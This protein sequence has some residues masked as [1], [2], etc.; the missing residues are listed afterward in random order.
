MADLALDFLR[1]QAL[2]NA[3]SC[4]TSKSYAI[5]LQQFF[6][7]VS[8]SRPSFKMG[9]NSINLEYLGDFTG[10]EQV[11]LTLWDEDLLLKWVFQAQ[12]SWASLSL[13][14]RNRKASSLKSFLSW[15]QT[16]G[17]IQKDLSSRIHAPKV[18][19]KI[20]NFLSVDEC[21]ALIKNLQKHALSNKLEDQQK[22]VL[23]LLLYG[24]GLRV[25]EACELKWKDL[26][27]KEKKLLVLGKGHKERWIVLPNLSVQYLSQL[28]QIGEFVFGEKSLS[29]R[30]AYEWVRTAGIEAGIIRPLSP[31]AL[32]HSFATHILTSGADLRVLQELLGHESLN[33]TQ[34]YTHLSLDQLAN[35]L[36]THHPLG[37]KKD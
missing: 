26:K 3:A 35:K 36:E 32:R 28:P 17:H 8:F 2:I 9:K 12:N 10:S 23:V 15:L 20:P 1:F 34:K 16:E 14:T 31:H 19:Q 37:R 4:N 24:G 13:A 22:L 21:L 6:S 27:L 29:P 18:P 11:K 5:D 7:H 33:A 30:K 25:S